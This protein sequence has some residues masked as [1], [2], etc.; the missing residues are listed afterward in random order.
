VGLRLYGVL[1]RPVVVVSVRITR[2]GGSTIEPTTSSAIRPPEPPH[3]QMRAAAQPPCPNHPCRW[4]GPA[5]PA[6]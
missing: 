5:I 2:G 4:L 1:E 3:R 6:G